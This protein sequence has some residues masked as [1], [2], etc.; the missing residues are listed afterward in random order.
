MSRIRNI[1][2]T[3]RCMVGVSVDGRLPA[4]KRVARVAFLWQG[5]RRACSSGYRDTTTK[6]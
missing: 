4:G 2:V 6:A 5:L 1:A 3:I